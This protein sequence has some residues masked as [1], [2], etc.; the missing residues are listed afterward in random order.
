MKTFQKE[1]AMSD[2]E[3]ED[4][5]LIC[6][7]CGDGPFNDVVDVVQHLDQKHAEYFC[8]DCQQANHW[9]VP[10]FSSWNRLRMH[11]KRWHSDYRGSIPNWE[12]TQCMIANRGATP[13]E[14]AARKLVE[15]ELNYRRL[16]VEQAQINL[17]AEQRRS[18]GSAYF[19]PVGNSQMI[20]YRA[21]MRLND[22]RN[23]R[24]VHGDNSNRQ[25][26][27]YVQLAAAR[28]RIHP[29]VTF[30]P[31]ASTS[32]APMLIKKIIKNDLQPLEEGEIEDEPSQERTTSK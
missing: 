23:S 4:K 15:A 30:E 14:E 12:K 17:V 31:I 9:S 22:R 18:I 21:P 10:Q 7:V 6:K 27:D 29:R 3:P 5:P 28:N 25:S 2:S 32:R 24:D 26:R 20:A 1:T 16:Q 13:V 8:Y 11:Q 19:A